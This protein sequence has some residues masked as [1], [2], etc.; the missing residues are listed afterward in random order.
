MG[1]PPPDVKFKNDVTPPEPVDGEKVVFYYQ[2]HKIVYI[3]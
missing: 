1:S 3:S 2:E